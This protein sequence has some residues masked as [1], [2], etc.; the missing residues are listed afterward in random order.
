MPRSIQN[1]AIP[2]TPLALQIGKLRA[3]LDNLQMFGTSQARLDY[4]IRDAQ[5][6]IKSAQGFQ[7]LID[8]TK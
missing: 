1:Q 8:D 6:L 7:G 4:L 5:I 3:T 2:T